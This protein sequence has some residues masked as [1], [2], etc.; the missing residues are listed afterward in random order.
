VRCVFCRAEVDSVHW[1]FGGVDEQ[2]VPSCRECCDRLRLKVWRVERGKGTDL[3][4]RVDCAYCGTQ[5]P[6]ADTFPVI[7]WVKGEHGVEALCNACRIKYGRETQ[8]VTLPDPA[9]AEMDQPPDNAGL[10]RQLLVEGAIDLR[11]GALFDWTPPP[12]P[13]GFD[14]DRIDGMLLGLAVGDAL[15][16]TTEG[17]V[18]TERR[19][20]YGEIRDYVPHWRSGAIATPSDDTQLAFWTLDQLLLDDG[21]VPERLARRFSSE[22]IVGV[23]QSVSQAMRAL[24]LGGRPWYECGSA[25]AGNGALMRIAPMLVPYVRS[26]ATDLWADAALSAV[27]THNDAASTSACLAFVAMLWQLLGMEQA[28]EPS[29]WRQ[30]YVRRARDLEGDTQYEP[31]AGAFAGYRGPL[32]RFVDERLSAAEAAGLTVLEACGQ[33]WSGAYLL[34]TVPSALYILARHAD[35]PEEALVRAVNDTEDN[36]TIAAIVGGAVGALHGAAA[37]PGRWVEQ[38]SGRTREADD[39]EVQRIVARARE[40][41]G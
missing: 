4:L 11:R 26:P 7:V 9:W 22:R 29:W 39:G 36:D 2:P 16:N 13:A 21:L 35:D 23:G 5:L 38:L 24:R 17:R 6:S 12:M 40:R 20:T 25:S 14:W 28:P 18:P 19:G 8:F 15:G 32:W 34:E 27:V 31:R 1:A 10:L 41:W 3:P 30:T 37:L 33:W